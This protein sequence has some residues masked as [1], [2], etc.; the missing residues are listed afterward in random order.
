MSK[1]KKLAIFDGKVTKF[2][3]KRERKE[4]VSF[5]ERDEI[6]QISE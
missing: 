2:L 4:L 6:I 1:A 5:F 3:S